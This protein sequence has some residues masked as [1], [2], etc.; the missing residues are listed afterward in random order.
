M[1]IILALFWQ[2]N[3]HCFKHLM[4]F[5]RALSVRAYLQSWALA[6]MCGTL[7]SMPNSCNIR[8]LPPPYAMLDDSSAS[9][10][11]GATLHGGWGWGGEGRIGPKER[12]FPFQ[13]IDGRGSAFCKSVPHNFGQDCSLPTGS[14]LH[15]LGKFSRPPPH[16]PASLFYSLQFLARATVQ[17]K[18]RAATQQVAKAPDLPSGV[19]HW[20]GRPQIWL[21]PREPGSKLVRSLPRLTDSFHPSLSRPLVVRNKK[22]SI[23]ALSKIQ[24]RSAP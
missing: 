8:S 5:L 22:G 13:M 10:S 17:T 18:R 4:L 20:P 12:L 9:L 2:K 14:P 15:F 6:K 3:K 24:I 21:R 1:S 19:C 23:W 7:S 16:S 11:L